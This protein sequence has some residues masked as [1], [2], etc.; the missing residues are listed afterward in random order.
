[1]YPYLIRPST[2]HDELIDDEKRAMD[3]IISTEAGA[4]ITLGGTLCHATDGFSI[5]PLQT[6]YE[7]VE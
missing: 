4:P 6:G 5:G 2:V 7:R 1:M 3:P